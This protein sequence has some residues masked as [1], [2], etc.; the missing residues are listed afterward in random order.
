M[1]S[2]EAEAVEVAVR[3]EIESQEKI[4]GITVYQQWGS[5]GG[6]IWAYY[7]LGTLQALSG[8]S[9][10]LNCFKEKICVSAVG[11]CWGKGMGLLLFRNVTGM[12]W[13]EQCPLKMFQF[14][15]APSYIAQF[16]HG[17]AYRRPS[18]MYLLVSLNELGQLKAIN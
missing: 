13:L 6:R 12:G 14:C 18:S 8:W 4:C 17:G 16:L 5:A 9:N 3:A 1:H 2:S 11:Q 15:N 10:A 7:C